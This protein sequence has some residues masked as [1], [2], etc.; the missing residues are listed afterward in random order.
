MKTLFKLLQYA[1]ERKIFLILSLI[2]SAL[3]TILSFVPYYYFWQILT[4]IIGTPSA[5]RLYSLSW[6]VFLWSVLHILVYFL[7]LLCSHL[8]AFRIET[9]MKRHG[10]NSLLHASFSFFDCESSGRARKILDDNTGNTHLIIAHLLPDSVNALLFPICLLFIAFLSDISVGFLMLTAILLSCLC[11]RHMYGPNSN[12]LML[13]Y[14][15]ALETINTETVEYIRGIQVIKIFNT[16]ITSFQKLHHAILHYA[17]IVNRQCQ[18]CRTPYTLFQ[19]LMLILG[20]LFIPLLQ[21]RFSI[22]TQAL[23]MVR[24]I[25]FAS[26]FVGLLMNAFMK[27]MFFKQNLN[28]GIDAYTKLHN[29]L[30][31]MDANRLLRGTRETFLSNDIHLHDVT[32]GYES[33]QKILEHFNL[34]LP[35]GRIYA[36]VGPSGGGKS[37]LAKL[38]SGFYPVQGGSVQI[39]NHSITEYSESALS[40]QIAFVFQNSK[41]FPTS[42]YENVRIGRPEATREEIL[43]A[44]HTARCDDIL[45]KFPE[46]E[47]TCIGSTGVHLSGGEIQRICIARALLKDAP[48][49]ILDEASAASDPENEHEM[50]LAF[51]ALM[52]NK[53]VILIAHRLSSI[54][55]VDEILLIENGQIVERGSHQKLM[56]QNGHYAK[57]VELYDQTESWRLA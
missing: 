42:L 56:R 54:R 49:I 11:F 16:V 43:N 29:L 28:Q 23:Q 4:E 39:G 53:T 33:G 5:E 13:E 46:R 15:N 9:N 57:W 20:A 45:K 10:L 25:A 6:Q 18:I 24:L 40:R 44:L 55:G 3:A 35:A 37:T 41:L 7:C 19:T 52:K 21:M 27:I 31:R 26:T 50:Q 12:N 32:F 48:I 22:E 34:T 38:I 1:P 8:F 51:S 36:L 14:M 30:T 2:L 47:N 17:E